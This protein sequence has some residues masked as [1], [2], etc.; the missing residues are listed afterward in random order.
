MVFPMKYTSSVSA[1]GF[2]VQS[3][4][5]DV[6]SGERKVDEQQ[7]KLHRAIQ[8]KIRLAWSSTGMANAGQGATTSGE[9]E[10]RATGSAVR[11]NQFGPDTI[12]WVR[13]SQRIG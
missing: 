1:D 9:G 11:S 13:T 7:V 10:I 8:A 5:V 12:N 2:N 6:P 4:S 3:G